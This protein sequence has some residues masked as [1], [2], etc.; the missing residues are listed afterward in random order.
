MNKNEE[1]FKKAFDK[2][3][4]SDELKRKTIENIENSKNKKNVYTLRLFPM[5]MSC[6]A[7]LLVIFSVGLFAAKNN[8][9]KV[10]TDDPNK[11]KEQVKYEPLEGENND[12]DRKLDVKRFASEDELKEVIEKSKSSRYYSPVYN[13]SM[14]FSTAVE[15]SAADTTSASAS[16]GTNTKSAADY[17]TTNIQ[18]AGVD[19]ADVVKTDGKTIFY[20]ANNVVY[21]VNANP[22]EEK[23]VIDIKEELEDVSNG[24][25]SNLYLADNKLILIGYFAK[26][27]KEIDDGYYPYWTYR[28]FTF[29]K[30][31]DVADVTKPKCINSKYLEGNYLDSRMIGD[32]LY[33]VANKSFYYYS[34]DE[35]VIN[36][37]LPTYYENEDEIKTIASTD[38]VYFP[39]YYANNF[40]MISGINIKTGETSEIETIYGGS[41]TIYCS[42]KY[43][44]LVRQ[45]YRYDKDKSCIYKVK[46]DEGKTEIVAK[47]TVNGYI[48]NQFALDEYDGNLRIATSEENY[49]MFAQRYIQKNHMYVL[50]D[51]LIVIGKTDDYGRGERI[52]SVRFV[53]ELAY[54][55]T[56]KQIDPLFIMDLSDP[57]NPKITG[58]LKIPG[59]SSYLH[60]YDEDHVIGIGYETEENK[61]G[62]V[63]NKALKMTMFDVSDIE[64]PKEDFTIE[65]GDYYSYSPVTSNHKALFFNKERNLIGFPISGDSR[66]FKVYK[67]EKDKFR[68]YAELTNDSWYSYYDSRIIY[69]EDQFYTLSNTKIVSYDMNTLEKI[70]ELKI[71]ES[72]SASSRWYDMV[73]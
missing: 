33:F 9:F 23:A 37:I 7:V 10:A 69:I 21:L 16:F 20:I 68:E 6:A 55:V 42:E 18:V 25:V 2:I 65:I 24:S 44:Y 14:S 13:S 45:D 72:S 67:I 28:Y 50:D 8:T 73:Y 71:N 60:P 57:S 11:V 70:S 22:L 15:E 26:K 1:D 36:D 30:I 51:D 53:N 64:N 48:I 66:G 63:S 56:F 35:L 62:G 54:V 59:Y 49:N 3:Q 32:Y 12:E 17:S 58:E 5:L 31:Y 4:A 39:D 52:Y 41:S 61:W 29:V 27:D 38:I 34:D 47:N 46:L 19:E 40:M 43:M